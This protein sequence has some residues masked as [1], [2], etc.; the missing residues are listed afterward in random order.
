MADNNENITKLNDLSSKLSFGFFLN[1]INPYISV[2]YYVLPDAESLIKMLKGHKEL[3]C[4]DINTLVKEGID[5]AREA[6]RK[7]RI[8]FENKIKCSIADRLDST[9]EEVIKLLNFIDNNGK[10]SF[11]FVVNVYISYCEQHISGCDYLYNYFTKQYPLSDELKRLNES[12]IQKVDETSHSFVVVFQTVFHELEKIA[13]YE[14]TK[15]LLNSLNNIILL[16]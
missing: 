4:K 7:Q 1:I 8:G 11:S 2:V 6:M 10:G 15:I 5:D 12:S 14:E 3:S 9:S 16:F 13:M